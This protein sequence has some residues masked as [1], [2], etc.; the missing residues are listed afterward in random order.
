MLEEGYL[1]TDGLQQGQAQAG[2]NDFQG[3]AW[4]AG[5]GAYV[6]DAATGPD[7]GRDGQEDGEGVEEMEGVDLLMSSD[8]GEV[9]APVPD[10]QFALMEQEF[11]DLYIG[12]GEAE[13]GQALSECGG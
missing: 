8:T 7:F 2:E 3:Y 6:N 11:A 4:E 1:F 10:F 13:L 5:A 12:Q 9:H